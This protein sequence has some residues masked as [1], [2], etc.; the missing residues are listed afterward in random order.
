[1]AAPMPASWSRAAP[2]H[3]RARRCWGMTSAW[4]GS[5][6][7]APEHVADLIRRAY[8]AIYPAEVERDERERQA[9]N[10]I[11]SVTRLEAAR[12][13]RL[14]STDENRLVTT[15][16]LVRMLLIVHFNLRRLPEQRAELYMQVVDTLLTS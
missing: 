2:R 14:G 7:L 1:M 13:A 12:A 16:L 3:T 9:T 15:P 8:H 6:A 10:L 4:C 11:D 5:L